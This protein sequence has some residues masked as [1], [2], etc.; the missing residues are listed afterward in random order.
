M[1]PPAGAPGTVF[2][3]TAQGFMPG[4]QVK[5]T[6]DPPAGRTDVTDPAVLVA[7][8]DGDATWTWT[9][10]E[11]IQAGEYRLVAQGAESKAEA[12]AAVTIK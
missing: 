8:G 11:G 12:T 6:L 9:A 10:H 4:E 2:L 1:N 5:V 7:Q 3:F